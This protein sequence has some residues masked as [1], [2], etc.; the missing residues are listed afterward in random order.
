MIIDEI[1]NHKLCVCVSFVCFVKVSHSELATGSLP[2][3]SVTSGSIKQASRKRLCGDLCQLI[4]HM[5]SIHQIPNC[6]S[7]VCVV[8]GKDCYHVCSKCVGEAKSE[9]V[10]DPSKRALLETHKV[11]L[12]SNMQELIHM[13]LASTSPPE[14]P[15]GVE[16]PLAVD[17]LVVGEEPV[18]MVT[19]MTQDNKQGTA[20]V[21]T[22]SAVNEYLALRL[23]RIQAKL[24]ANT[25]ERRV[26]EEEARQV[27]DLFLG[28]KEEAATEEETAN[29]MTPTTPGTEEC[30]NKSIV[31]K[32]TA[33]DGAYKR[34][35][36]CQPPEQH[37]VCV[38]PCQAE[39]TLDPGRETSSPE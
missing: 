33:F 10:T 38:P 36:D 4:D 3:S 34:H 24:A 8:Y 26:L 28:Q 22:S 14:K 9:G 35:E 16:K 13:E 27:E 5:E 31:Q 37:A 19:E 29:L 32:N 1:R 23:E 25:E 20:K 30:C 6:N 21:N 17:K 2:S 7:K 39:A 11:M 18:A 15:W 12:E